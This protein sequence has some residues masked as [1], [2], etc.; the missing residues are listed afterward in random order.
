MQAHWSPTRLSLLQELLCPVAFTH[1]R[2]SAKIEPASFWEQIWIAVLDCPM[3]RSRAPFQTLLY[4]GAKPG[5]MFAERIVVEAIC[6]SQLLWKAYQTD[7]VVPSAI[8]D[9]SDCLHVLKGDFDISPIAAARVQ[10]AYSQCGRALV[11]LAHL[12]SF[13]LAVQYN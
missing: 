11:G 2:I 10:Q 3:L 4:R 6:V 13:V 12:H 5:P 1:E 7:M 9:R 8:S